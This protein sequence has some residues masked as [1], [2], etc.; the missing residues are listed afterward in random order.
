[1]KASLLHITF[2][3]LYIALSLLLPGNLYAQQAVL[4][5]YNVNDGLPNTSTHGVYQDKYGYLWV[6]PLQGLADL[7]GD[8]L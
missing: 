1:M 8:N 2:N 7:T 6:A 4:K 5:L 3:F